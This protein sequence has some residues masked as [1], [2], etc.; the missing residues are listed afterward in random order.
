MIGMTAGEAKKP[1]RDI[2][3]AVKLVFYRIA[4]VYVGSLFFLSLVIA[5]DDPR[6]LSGSSKTARSPF[7][8][9]FTNV[10]YAQA[11]NVLNAIIVRKNA[12]RSC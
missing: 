12:A 7:V 9:A 11:G 1:A 6:M 5:W 3:R 10:G 4:V 8:L 2:P